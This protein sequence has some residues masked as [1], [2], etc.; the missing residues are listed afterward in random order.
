MRASEGRRR[1]HH[2]HVIRDQHSL[3][4]DLPEAATSPRKTAVIGL[5]RELASQWAATTY[6]STPI[7]PGFFSIGVAEGRG[8][9]GEAPPMA[10]PRHAAR[11][12]GRADGLDGAMVFLLGD[13][14]SLSPPDAAR[15]RRPWR[16]ADQPASGSSQGRPG[17]MGRR[18]RRLARLARHVGGRARE[19]LQCRP[20]L[21]HARTARPRL[22]AT[23]NAQSL[24]CGADSFAQQRGPRRPRRGRDIELPALRP[25]IPPPAGVPRPPGSAASPTSSPAGR[26]ARRRAR[27]GSAPRPGARRQAAPRASSRTAASSRRPTCHQ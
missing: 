10:G 3:G 19:P 20:G 25:A 26:R 27:S 14:S 12:L 18:R 8:T 15:R 2:E 5:T 4:G 11:A 7:A 13:A 24:D 21:A 9:G 6:G 17:E 23:M 1:L 16:R 22:A